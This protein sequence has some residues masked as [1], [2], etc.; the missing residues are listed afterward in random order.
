MMG[1]VLNPEVVAL[2]RLHYTD[3]LLPAR[4]SWWR[5]LMRRLGA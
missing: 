5:R 4:R 1:V 3:D 2:M